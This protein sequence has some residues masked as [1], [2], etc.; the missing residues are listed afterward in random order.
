M[1]PARRY[2]QQGVTL[3][4]VAIAMTIMGI[5]MAGALELYSRAHAQ[6]ELD[7]TYDNIDTVTE[8]LS[9]YVEGKGRLPCP[10]DPSADEKTFGQERKACDQTT[11]NG[12]LPFVTLGISRQ[13]AMDGWG[14][15]YTYAVSPVF[16]RT[17]DRSGAI[18]DNGKIHGRCRHKGWVDPG[19]RYNRNAIKA[20]F[21]CAD[22]SPPAF[23]VDSDLIILHTTGGA[24]S[25]VRSP[26]ISN[27]YDDLTRSTTTRT[28]NTDVPFIDTTPVEAPAFVLVSHGKDG[29]GAWLGNGTDHKYNSPDSGPELTNANNGQVFV[30]GP[31][32]LVPGPAY[33]DDIVRWMS[34]DSIMAAHGARSCA[35]P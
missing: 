25:P 22:Q 16:A 34:Q 23:D 17:N 30:D 33:Y 35:Y 5:I 4:E 27:S 9:V 19:D 15:Y 21:C 29:R 26:G 31:W 10:A 14:R 1:T 20:R 12:I 18:A 32:N 6:Q 3:V 13:A 2:R 11:R 24:L 28:G 7:A 8:A